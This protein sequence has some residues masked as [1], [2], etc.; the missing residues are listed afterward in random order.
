[1]IEE[2]AIAFSLN[3]DVSCAVQALLTSGPIAA[4]AAE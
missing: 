1:V 4:T 2:G 3:I